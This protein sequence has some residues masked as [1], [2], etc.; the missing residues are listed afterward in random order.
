MTPE[1]RR[2]AIGTDPGTIL[3]PVVQRLLRKKMLDGAWLVGV[4]RHWAG[5]KLFQTEGPVWAKKGTCAPIDYSQPP[6]VLPFAFP[7]IR[8]V[9]E[10]S[11][12]AQET[13]FRIPAS[14]RYPPG[15]LPPR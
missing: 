6:D 9:G 8:E 15:P 4:K 2:P 11:K 7:E 13:L 10:L 12:D 14:G 1:S 5:G 3:W